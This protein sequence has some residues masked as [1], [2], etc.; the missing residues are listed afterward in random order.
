M[1]QTPVRR[2]RFF[3][4]AAD[5]APLR[6]KL[7][8]AAARVIDSGRYILG[9]EVSGFEAQIAELLGVMPSQVVGVSCGTDALMIALLAAG[10]GPGD[11]V[12]VPAY[13]FIATASAVLWVGA[14]PIF[15][16]VDPETLNIDPVDVEALVTPRTRAIIP[17]HLFGCAADMD[18][19]SAI[20]Q[21]ASNPIAVIEDTAQAL[22]GGW[23]GQ[24][25]GTLGD[26]GVVSFFPTK[27]LGGLGDGGVVVCRDP[28]QAA[29]TRSLR[30]HGCRVR[31]VH[32]RLGFNARL[33]AMAAAFLSVKLPRLARACEARRANADRYRALIEAAGLGSQVECPPGDTEVRRVVYNQFLVHTDHRDALRDHLSANG[34][35]TQVYYPQALPGQPVFA[36][37]PQPRTQWPVS[38]AAAKRS[39]ALPIAPGLDPEGQRYLVEVMARFFNSQPHRA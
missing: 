33:D 1:S 4:A 13:T 32:E 6:A 28:D 37:T 19:L 2:V 31:Y 15:A 5:N 7:L 23:R 30:A 14:T 27:N 35:E 34:V 25:L 29:K 3:D 22:G 38:E 11:E 10:V 26:F 21:R 17:V 18:A 12:I 36:E 8:E 16:D 39:L 20:A 24:M 9:P